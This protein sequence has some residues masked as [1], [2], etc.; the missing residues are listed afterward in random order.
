M[1]DPVIIDITEPVPQPVV[2]TIDEGPTGPQGPAGNTGPQGPIGN[3]GPQGPVG[4]TGPQG[5]TGN[6]GPQGQTGNTGPQGPVGSDASVTSSN[7]ATALGYTP[8]DDA[9]VVK[10]TGTQTI[11]GT[12]SFSGQ[13]ELTGQAAING[14]SALTRNLSVIERVMR[15]TY[16][17]WDM[18]G[19]YG[20]MANGVHSGTTGSYSVLGSAQAGTAI[21]GWSQVTL[22][23]FL[24]RTGGTGQNG[25]LCAVPIAIAMNGAWTVDNTTSVIRLIAGAAITGTPANSTQPQLAA[26][27]FGVEWYKVGSTRMIRLFAHNG[28]TLTVGAGVPWYGMW[29]GIGAIIVASDGTGNIHLWMNGSDSHVALGAPSLVPTCSITGGPTDN[30]YGK[31]GANTFVNA[32][33]VVMVATG[34]NVAASGALWAHL[35]GRIF[36][37]SRIT[38]TAVIP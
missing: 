25:G 17:E 24:T 26:R 10:K 4:N 1:A 29:T 14:T 5:P 13:V 11:A 9:A 3:I 27:G 32:G 34:D 37:N 15:A 22:C 28:Y 16:D 36:L 12:K 18:T 31:S 38:D 2:I 30:Q 35:R 7:I 21:G 19:N 20:G 6:T 23:Q 8:A 33:A